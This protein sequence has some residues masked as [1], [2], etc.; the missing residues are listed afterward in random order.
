MDKND[1]ILSAWESRYINPDYDFATGE[2]DR[3][4]PQE[5]ENEDEEEKGEEK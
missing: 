4:E 1:R 2:Y 5:D 3:Q